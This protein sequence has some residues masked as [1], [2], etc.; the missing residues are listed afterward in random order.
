MVLP[1]TL[2]IVIYPMY[3]LA[4]SGNVIFKV[5]KITKNLIA[6]KWLHAGFELALRFYRDY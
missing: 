5:N 4:W 6:S 2:D 1:I 3:I